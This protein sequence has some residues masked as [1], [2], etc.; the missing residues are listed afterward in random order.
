MQQFHLGNQSR[1]GFSFMEIL[2][3]M[4][5]IGIVG[6]SIFSIQ[7]NSWKNSRSSNRAIVAAHL[8]EQRIELIRLTIDRDSKKNFPPANGAITENGVTLS[9]EIFPAFRPT[10]GGELTNV[11]RCS[12][13]ATWG[14]GKG[15]SV[16]VT[17][18]L[19]KMF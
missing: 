19:S 8:I 13:L 7:S 6:V 15:D 14:D 17:T 4:A 1:P 2:V 3:S 5:I 18:Y 12:M 11:R 16:K 10:N 9:W